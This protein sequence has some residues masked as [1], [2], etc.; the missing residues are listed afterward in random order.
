MGPGLLYGDARG[1]G[2]E[3]SAGS[4]SGE[5]HGFLRWL[6]LQYPDAAGYWPAQAV[7]NHGL[8]GRAVISSS[9]ALS[10]YPL[11]DGSQWDL[12]GISG[13][14][15]A[16]L[17]EVVID[18][19]PVGKADGV[20]VDAGSVD[21]LSEQLV[22]GAESDGDVLVICGSSLVVWSV[23]PGWREVPGLWTVPHTVAGKALIGGSTNAGGIFLGWADRLLAAAGDREPDPDEVPVWAPYPRGERTPLHDPSRRAALVDLSLR[24]DAAAARRAA[25]E[26]AGFVVR[27][28]IELAGVPPTRIVATG[29]GTNVPGWVRALAD[30]TGLPVDVVAV[31][32]GAALGAAFLARLAA[33]LEANML[34]ARRWA[35]IARRESPRAEW[36][37]PTARRYAR[38]KALA[39]GSG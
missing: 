33:G 21:A 31:P 26:A 5:C 29:G 32:S 35:R 9:T 6:A 24:H 30:C 8:A 20:V 38:F 2:A 22:S 1:Q 13:V 34:D 4:Y 7:A 25:F 28:H 23:S 3:R 12:G 27:L 11:Y 15:A 19:T 36:A 18:G 10:A 37:E 14:D 39:F 16:Q 17:P